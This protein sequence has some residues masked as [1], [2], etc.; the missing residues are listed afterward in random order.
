MR[1]LVSTVL[2]ALFG[3]YG[4]VCVVWSLQCCM[5]CLVSTVWYA[6]FGLY[7][8]V[9]VVWFRQCCMC[10]LVKNTYYTVETKQHIL[11]CRDKITHTTPY[12]PNNTYYTVEI[13]QHILH[14]RDQATHTT[15]SRPNNCFLQC[16]M[17]CLFSTVLYV[18]LDLY[19]VVCVVWSLQCCMRCLV[20]YYTVETKQHILHRKVQ[21]THST[22]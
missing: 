7:I 12:R 6:L 17:C 11:H 9:C 1:C 2:Y 3:L 18:L 5:C 13:K 16:S 22:P 19:S 21:T 4:V 20:S 14:C 15:L 8:A 10:C